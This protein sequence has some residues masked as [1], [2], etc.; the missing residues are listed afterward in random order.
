[1]GGREEIGRACW[2]GEGWK[3]QQNFGDSRRP[4]AVT[5]LGTL[6]FQDRI[7]C[8]TRGFHP[9]TRCLTWCRQPN[10]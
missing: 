8:F 1:M 5:K 4:R 2:E 3:S 9:G 10:R 6:E 7:F